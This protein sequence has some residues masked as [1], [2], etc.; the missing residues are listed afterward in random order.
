[1][2]NIT[3]QQV[4]VTTVTMKKQRNTYSE[5]VSV[6]LVTQQALYISHTILPSVTCPALHFSALSHKQQDF[7]KNN[8]LNTKCVFWISLQ[9]VSETF[10][11]LRRIQ[12]ILSQM[13]TGLHVKYPL[14]SSDFKETWTFSIDF[15][16]SS[17]TEFHK[18]L[19]SRSRWM[20]RHTQQS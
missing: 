11:I 6:A 18:N 16:K 9:H 13:N 7:W 17:I 5:H 15:Q 19:S 12:G 4:P 1:M 3:F 8:V 14:L 10:L 20:D 2:Y